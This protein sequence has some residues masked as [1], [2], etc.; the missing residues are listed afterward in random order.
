M[1]QGAVKICFGQIIYFRH[2]LGREIYFHVA[3]ARENLF[4]C[5]HGKPQSTEA[6]LI[7]IETVMLLKAVQ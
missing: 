1:G 3:W 2:E 5:K 6:D 4:S 7:T